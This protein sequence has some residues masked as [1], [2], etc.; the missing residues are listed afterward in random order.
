[1]HELNFIFDPKQL[2]QS[3]IGNV[4]KKHGVF[5][6]HRDM[7]QVIIEEPL[8]NN[9]KKKILKD[10][11]GYSI[12]IVGSDEI[13]LVDKIKNLLRMMINDSEVRKEK[14][15]AVL[16]DRLDLKYSFLS[17]HFANATYTSIEKFYLMLKIEKAKELLMKKGATVTDVA[18][19]LDYS[20]T[21]HLSRQFKNVTGLSI[22]QYL[23]LI[24]NRALNR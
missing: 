24:E 18:F 19:K 7:G 23:K 8:P 22:S 1:M 13:S 12:E 6:K 5:F 4:L 21:S 9:L 11:R 17:K 20:S 2:S 15:S 10:L 16:S 3:I 14:I